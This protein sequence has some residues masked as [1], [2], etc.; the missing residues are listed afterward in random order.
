MALTFHLTDKSGRLI[1]GVIQVASTIGTLTMCSA[2]N[3]T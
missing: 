1:F 2:T 3:H